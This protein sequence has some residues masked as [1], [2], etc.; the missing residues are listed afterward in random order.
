MSTTLTFALDQFALRQFNHN[1]PTY[2]G[3]III[4]DVDDFVARVNKFYAERGSD[5]LKDG[6]AD[7]CKHLY[8]PNFT[9]AH[10]GSLPLSEETLPFL[11]TGYMARTAQELPVLCRW[12]SREDFE[13]ISEAP[14]LDIICYSR[15]QIIKEAKARNEPLPT[16]DSPWGII[17]IKAQD[18]DYETPMQPITI[19]R[20]ALI[21]EGGSGVKINRKKYM[22]AVKYW[23]TRA[24]LQ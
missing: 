4:H 9:K 13:N 16:Y 6:Y 8:I 7:F 1:D 15:E 20:N 12:F 17:S 3:T 24:L 19:M 22:E 11:K 5:C 10:V 23:E 14:F 2:K 21:E 18:V